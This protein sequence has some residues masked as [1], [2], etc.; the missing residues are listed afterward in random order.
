MVRLLLYR[1]ISSVFISTPCLL[2][3]VL[4]FTSFELLL[5]FESKNV[6]RCCLSGPK[7]LIQMHVL[8]QHLHFDAPIIVFHTNMMDA[9][10]DIDARWL[11]WVAARS[12]FLPHATSYNSSV[13]IF[14]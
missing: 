3:V 10:S 6:Q 7:L 4:Y 5:P 2:Q 9:T 14:V 13:D 1:E 8:G 11:P 12:S